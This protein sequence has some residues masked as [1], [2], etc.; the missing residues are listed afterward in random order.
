MDLS[1]AIEAASAADRAPRRSDL[2]RRLKEQGLSALPRPPRWWRPAEFRRPVCGLG[3]EDSSY[4]EGLR[5]LAEPPPVL[6]VRGG[7][8][9]LP[10]PRAAVAIVGS[11]RASETGLRVAYDLARGLAQEGVAVLSGLAL[12]VDSAAHRGCLDG[13]GRTLAVLAS[14]VDQPT[15]LRHVALA[16]GILSQGGWLV[17]ERPPGATVRAHEFPRRNRIIAALAGLVVVVEA[18]LRSGTLSTVEHA[19]RLGVE[20]AAV[21]G[22][23]DRP[24]CR[25]SNALLRRGA[26]WVESVGDLL[27]HLGRSPVATE[28]DPRLDEDERAVLAGLPEG[29]GAP[30]HWC[31]ASS[32]PPERARSA[33]ARLVSKGVLRQ[34][35]C[36]RVARVL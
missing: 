27:E 29:A 20:V 16:E 4:P 26:Q 22:P 10:K 8:S 31:A 12:G 13:G 15:P 36:G 18:G 5:R 11:R 28:A 33:L 25:G 3:W 32:L 2:Y 23:I 19:L 6:F 14:P 34:L 35:G 1:A 30:G 17:S 24:G 21:P 7:A 9:D